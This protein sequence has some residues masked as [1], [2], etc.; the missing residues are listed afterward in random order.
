MK[1]L[2]IVIALIPFLMSCGNQEQKTKIQTSKKSVRVKVAPVK[3]SK[4]RKTLTYSG[5]IE[6]SQTIPLSF[7]SIEKVTHIY[8]DEGDMVEKGQLLA[9]TDKERMESAY[10]SA[11][12]QYEQAIDARDR[13]KKVYDA[14][15]LP[16]IKWVEIKT[17]VLQAKA[18]R[19][20][21]KKN[22][23]NCELYAP[24]DGFIGARNIEVGMNAGQLL[25]PFSLVKIEIVSAKISV[26]ENEI[27]L[28]EIG[29][30][31]MIEVS[32]LNDKRYN[33]L[34]EKVGVVANQLSRTYDVK[35]D[36]AN[37]NFML[38]P[39]MVCEVL[40][41]LPTTEPVLLIPVSAVDTDSRNKPTVF[42]VDRISKVAVKKSIQIS[43]IVNDSICV[44]AGLEPNDLIVV[45]GN[46]K[47]S[48]NTVV[49]W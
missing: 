37:S 7:L 22:L 33:G 36:L 15:S 45:Q 20:M 44:S 29:Q 31:A 6:A 28:L 41:T 5:T 43:G 32:A 14:G 13:L 10:Q 12:A 8:V 17:K 30:P 34:V 38:K 9:E 19:D 40:V 4:E 25:A 3:I 35:I 11:L 26:P 21:F 39:G 16:E 42:A 2:L 47:I 48:N 18:N 49:S 24:T 27:S 1:K 46:Q 23:E